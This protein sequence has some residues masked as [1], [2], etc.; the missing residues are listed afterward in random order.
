V[1]ERKTQ[2]DLVAAMLS[3][4][5]D[6]RLAIEQVI[7]AA[8][9]DPGFHPAAR[10]L[11]ASAR[12][13]DR[14]P[15]RIRHIAHDPDL[16]RKAQRLLQ[17]R[18]ARR[19]AAAGGPAMPAMP[20]MQVGLG[21]HYRGRS[22]QDEFGLVVHVAE[23]RDVPAAERIQPVS[24][25]HDGV[26]HTLR[27]DVKQIERAEKQADIR[28]GNRAVVS[29]TSVRG[30]LG[31]IAMRATG[32]VAL[33]SGH[34][35]RTSVGGKIRAREAGGAEIDLGAVMK[36][37]DDATMDAATVGPVPLGQVGSLTLDPAEIRDPGSIFRGIAVSVLVAGHSGAQD[38][39][40]D[41]INAPA[42][43]S[44]GNAMTGLIALAPRVTDPGDSGA[45]VVDGQG[46]LLGF[47]VGAS[48]TRTFVLAATE[49]LD[50]MLGA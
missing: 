7:R 13:Q 32:P 5:S 14:Q 46:Q 19:A 37:R 10:R 49:V 36:L 25:L 23:K 48:A 30:T 18:L 45:A 39:F 33:I 21:R 2:A 22:P 11:I 47:V 44:D 20:A 26:R 24:L 8:V 40:V 17:R 9:R 12:G 15:P 42:M 6:G 3:A 50:E 4:V 28:P 41:D 35:A 34:V 43:F 29:S 1:T 38:A 16:L 27:V 31:A